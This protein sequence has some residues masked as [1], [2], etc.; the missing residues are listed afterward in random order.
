[1]KIMAILRSRQIGKLF[2]FTPLENLGQVLS[3]GLIPRS[4]PSFNAL[5]R[6]PS[7]TDLGRLEQSHGANCL[8]ISHPNSNMLYS[9]QKA[10]FTFAL[11][12]ID[13]SVLWRKSWF[14]F[15]TNSARSALVSH[16]KGDVNNFRGAVALE[17]LF[18]DSAIMESQWPIPR[19]ANREA[20]GL[21]LSEPTDV[22]AEIAI[23]EVIEPSYFTRIF[24]RSLDS[25]KEV[26]P[27]K[28]EFVR[29]IPL[30]VRP[31]LFENRHDWA[32]NP[33]ARLKYPI[34][35]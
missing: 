7:I 12:G 8:S 22:Q 23:D 15:P 10:G 16:Y 14:A 19:T 29:N 18:V 33:G 32:Q 28:S 20:L 6:T 27:Y 31:E 13:L 4:C 26:R 25:F 24:L 34:E 21:K 2:H 35:F 30:E 17:R 9:K 5:V 11:I 3:T 1:M